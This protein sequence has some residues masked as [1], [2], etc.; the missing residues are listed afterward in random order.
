MVSGKCRFFLSLVL[1]FVLLV[2]LP[3]FQV[4]QLY[5]KQSARQ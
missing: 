5:M 3:P 2:F 4:P 1:A